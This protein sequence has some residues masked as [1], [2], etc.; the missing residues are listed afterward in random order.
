MDSS[1]FHDFNQGIFHCFQKLFENSNI[2][3][4]LEFLESN[5]STIK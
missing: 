1:L 2:A 5:D 3:D 4:I